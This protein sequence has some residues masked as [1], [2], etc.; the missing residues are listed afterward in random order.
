MKINALESSKAGEIIKKFLPSFEGYGKKILNNF[1]DFS[2]E[3]LQKHFRIEEESRVREKFEKV[4]IGTSKAHAVDMLK[5]SKKAREN[6]LGPKKD[7]D[8]LKNSN[9]NI[10]VKS[11]SFIPVNCREFVFSAVN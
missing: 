7:Q 2:L 11:L 6:M 1:E 4:S 5:N 8:K 9:K 3:Q 10:S